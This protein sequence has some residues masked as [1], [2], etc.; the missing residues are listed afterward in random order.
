M[1]VSTGRTPVGQLA[2]VMTTIGLL[3]NTGCGGSGQVEAPTSFSAATNSQQTKA[4]WDVKGIAPRVKIMAI[5]LEAPPSNP[6]EDYNETLARS[7]IYAATHGAM[8]INISQG[9]GQGSYKRC[10]R[11]E[12][13]DSAV[14][15]AFSRGVSV[16]TSAG[17][18]AMDN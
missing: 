4:T 3:A 7:I 10:Y 9:V 15:E 18:S 17:N 11:W 6:D 12:E 1:K 14:N 5:K 8:V 2:L 13:V 16:V